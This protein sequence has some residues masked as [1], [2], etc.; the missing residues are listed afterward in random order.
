MSFQEKIDK[1]LQEKNVKNLRQLANDVN[2]PYTTLWD[3]YSNPTRLEKAN[4]TNIKKIANHLGCTIDYLVFDNILEP[5]EVMLDNFD[6][7]KEVLEEKVI[8][9]EVELLFDKNKNILTQDDKDYIKF[10]I[11]K[12]KKEIDKELG[13]N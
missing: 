5:N 1:L 7:K 11:E 10:I 8:P 2:I 13:E 6:I 4:L 12:R 9:D 3:Y